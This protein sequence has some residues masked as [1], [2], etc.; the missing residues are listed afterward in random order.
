[1]ALIKCPRCGRQ[2]SNRAVQCPNC[3]LQFG[4]Y[5]GTFSKDALQGKTMHPCPECGSINISYQTINEPVK[6]NWLMILGYIFLALTCCG[7]LVLI[8][9]LLQQKNHMVTYATCQN[10]GCHWNVNDPG[11]IPINKSENKIK[12]EGSLSDYIIL[13]LSG[14]ILLL[15][16]IISVVL[17]KS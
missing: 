1:M 12:K 8:P 17:L 7:L 14:L 10:C 11:A 16:M 9:I 3:G 5:I 4:P 15:I 13:I 2:I 6:T